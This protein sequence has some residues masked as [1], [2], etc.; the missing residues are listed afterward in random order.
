MIDPLY[1]H[2]G[3]VEGS[4]LLLVVI[5]IAS[6]GTGLLFIVSYIAFIRRQRTQYLLICIAVGLLFLRSIVGAGT[7]LGY[8][9]MMLHHLVEHSFDFLVA[10]IVLYAAYE[11]APQSPSTGTEHADP[12]KKSE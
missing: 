2:L 7:V 4:L 12:S 6:L 1:I 5:C 9:P 10:A 11:H 3:N 8:V